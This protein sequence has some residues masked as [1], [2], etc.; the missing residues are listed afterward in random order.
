MGAGSHPDGSGLKFAQLPAAVAGSLRE[1]GDRIALAQQLLGG[2]E[3]LHRLARVLPVQKNAAQLLH[4]SADHRELHDLLFCHDG[5]GLVQLGKHQGDVKVSLMICHKDHRPLGDV[6]PP[7]CGNLRPGQAQ[8]TAGPVLHM[9]A[10]K[11]VV[12][13]GFSPFFHAAHPPVLRQHHNQIQPKIQK[14]DDGS[15]LFYLLSL[16]FLKSLLVLYNNPASL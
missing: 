13:L 9:L 5:V 7:G 14:P 3:A 10:D 11:P 6:L 16:S 12:P 1:D 2:L 15:H 4:P 8:Q